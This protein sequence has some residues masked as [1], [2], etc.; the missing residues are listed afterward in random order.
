MTKVEIA[1]LASYSALSSYTDVRKS[2]TRFII[3]ALLQF[4]PFGL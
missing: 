2:T 3:T 4:M 1:T